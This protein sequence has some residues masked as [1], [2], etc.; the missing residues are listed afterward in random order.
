MKSVVRLRHLVAWAAVWFVAAQADG[1]L[2]TTGL[3]AH[4]DASTITG[5]S[6]GALLSSWADQSGN[7]RNATSSSAAR[8][9]YIADG[10]NGLPVVRFG[11]TQSMSADFAANTFTVD[12]T[13]LFAVFRVPTT[14]TTQGT[15][16]SLRATEGV[17]S[18]ANQS[19][20][21]ISR[22]STGD[23]LSTFDGTSGDNGTHTITGSYNDNWPHLFAARANSGSGSSNNVLQRADGV[24][25]KL[26]S[27][28]AQQNAVNFISIGSLNDLASTRLIG[29]IAELLVYNRTLSTTEFAEN[30]AYLIQKYAIPEPSTAL[31]A[32]ACTGMLA[33]RRRRTA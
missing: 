33:L 13:T 9:T 26:Q 10:I 1:A 16:L 32:A 23:L 30:E 3:Q 22:Y 4:Y 18:G 12:G 5:V 20:M 25:Q 19:F 6:N 15:F 24:V 28:A 2:I 11:G 21:F 14:T 17:N 27:D 29:D 31:V 8:P 7:G